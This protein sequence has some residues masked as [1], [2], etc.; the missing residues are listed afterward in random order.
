MNDTDLMEK[1]EAGENEKQAP[2][3]EIEAAVP[4]KGKAIIGKVPT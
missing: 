2:P 3:Q 4:F 1:V